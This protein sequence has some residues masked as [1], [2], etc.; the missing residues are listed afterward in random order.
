MGKITRDE[1]LTELHRLANELDKVPTREEM[2]EHGKYSRS[3][4]DRVFGG[5]NDALE[6]AGLDINKPVS[7]TREQ[8][9]Q[10][11]ER[12][13]EAIGKSP[14]MDEFRNASKYTERAYKREFGTWNDALRAAGLEVNKPHGI[15]YPKLTCEHCGDEFPVKPSR[16]D[17]R[18][19]CSRSCLMSSRTGEQNPNPKSDTGDIVE[20]EWCGD[21]WYVP[22]SEIE[23]TRFCSRE[24]LGKHHRSVRSG[25]DSPRWNGGSNDW[26]GAN[27]EK[28]RKLAIKRDDKECVHCGMD[29]EEHQ[30]AYG[31]DLNVH[32]IK[33]FRSFNRNY[34]K[35]NKL[36]NLVTLCKE[37]HSLYE[38]LKIKQQRKKLPP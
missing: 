29:R 26:R 12:V 24:C 5:W 23:S 9:L 25:E 6:E 17:Y 33:E 19:Y 18:Q 10:E 15:E 1:L 36:S 34:E 22:P 7:L 27:W 13:A 31:S 11:L 38:H 32:H 16:V 8:L 4:Y 14:T 2:N 30:Q 37:C 3:P 28:Q 21:E 35:A 20:C